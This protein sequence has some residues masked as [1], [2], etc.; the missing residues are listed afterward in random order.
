VNGPD[1]LVLCRLRRGG[2]GGC[3]QALISA[4][5]ASVHATTG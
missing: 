5:R 4:S 2:I 3:R 1:V